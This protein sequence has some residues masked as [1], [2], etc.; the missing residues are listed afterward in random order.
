MDSDVNY[1][2]FN[3][4]GIAYDY[5]RLG[6]RTFSGPA[7][8]MRAHFDEEPDELGDYDFDSLSTTHDGFALEELIVRPSGETDEFLYVAINSEG[9]GAYTFQLYEESD[10]SLIEFELG[11]IL[12][13]QLNHMQNYYL[14]IAAN[15]HDNLQLKVIVKVN[16]GSVVVGGK[17]CTNPLEKCKG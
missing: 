12:F 10:G 15:Q 14:R 9:R 7:K 17:I 5:L 8:R 16:N 3:L 4:S 13:D 1:Y 6:M 11:Q 2:Q